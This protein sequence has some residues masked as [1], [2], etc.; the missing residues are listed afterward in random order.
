LYIPQELLPSISILVDGVQ[1]RSKGLINVLGAESNSTL[2]WV[3]HISHTLKRAYKSLHAI[4][5]AMKYFTKK[6]LNMLMTSN[7]TAFY[8]TS[9]KYGNC[10]TLLPI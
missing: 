4:K 1:V 5:I 9:L 8:I 10:L 7:F 2:Q 3:H 6:E